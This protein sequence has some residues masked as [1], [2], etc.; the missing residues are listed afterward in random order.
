MRQPGEARNPSPVGHEPRALGV[1]N[2]MLDIRKIA[3]CLKRG[4]GYAIWDVRDVEDEIDVMLLGS[5]VGDTTYTIT[6]R[7][8]SA[9]YDGPAENHG[10]PS[11]G[12]M[13]ERVANRWIEDGIPELRELRQ[14]RDAALSRVRVLEQQLENAI[15]TIHLLRNEG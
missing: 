6:V 4:G 1:M 3:D 9:S 11:Q 15:K 14:A 5:H 8:T 10:H 7:G 13:I 12:A 2:T